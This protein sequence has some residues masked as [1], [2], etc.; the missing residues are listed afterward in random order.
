MSNLLL[1]GIKRRVEDK[2]TTSGAD[3]TIVDTIVDDL[4]KLKNDLLKVEA[5]W[6]K[7]DHENSFS[8]FYSVRTVILVLEKII[9]RFQTETKDDGLQIAKDTL[10]VIPSI[11]TIIHDAMQYRTDD[12]LAEHILEK[13][14]QFDE[15]AYDANLLKTDE[16]YLENVD[17]DTII[18]LFE[19]MLDIMEIPKNPTHLVN[20]TDAKNTSRF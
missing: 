12:D 15:E 11:D 20:V 3:D 13:T 8:F 18:E 10:V 19:G 17:K 14:N 4:T 1:D 9:D 6:S 16:E 5:K 7:I 2:C